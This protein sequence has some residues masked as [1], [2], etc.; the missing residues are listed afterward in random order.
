MELKQFKE[1][2]FVEGERKGFSNVELYYEK[3]EKLQ[4][5]VY[6]VEVDGYESSTVKGASIRGLFKGKTGYAYTEKLDEDSV[7]FLLDHAAENA[8]LIEDDPEELFTDAGTYEQ[9]EF[10][11]PGLEAV[12]TKDKITFLKKVE[13]KI[14]AYDERVKQIMYLGIHRET[15]EKMLFHNQGLS[16]NEKNNFL[17]IGTA[18]LVEEN[19]ETKS[20]IYSKITKDFAAL[21]ADVIA[22]EVVEKGLSFLGGKSYPNK[23]YPVLLKNTAAAS[24][25][26]ERRVGKEWRSQWETKQQT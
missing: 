24:R 14:L 23:N 4:C 19:G 16:L 8:L 5:D 15:V 9:K 6:D 26:E 2:L 1:Q 13:E 18:V 21:D 10:Y 25:S 17:S 11:A 20:G 12:P 7:H 3:T 22:K